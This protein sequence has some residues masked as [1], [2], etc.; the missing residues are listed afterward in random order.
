MQIRNQRAAEAGV[1]AFER[2]WSVRRRHRDDT[3]G[4]GDRKRFN[5]LMARALGA[6]GIRAAT[7]PPVLGSRFDR[8]LVELLTQPLRRATS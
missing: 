7:V 1:R 2:A 5:V 4:E 3:N 8:E 6:G